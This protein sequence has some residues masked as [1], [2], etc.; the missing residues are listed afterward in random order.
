MFA[1]ITTMIAFAPWMLLD[2]ETVQFTRQISIVVIAAL[3][4]SLIESLLILPAHLSHIK[5]QKIRGIFAPFHNPVSGL[6]KSLPKS[7]QN[8]FAGER[9]LLRRRLRLHRCFG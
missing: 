2:G 7:S 4:F 5:E 8:R 9:R 3:S 6:P 1:V